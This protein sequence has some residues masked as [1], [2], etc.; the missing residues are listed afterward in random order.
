MTSNAG[1][2]IIMGDQMIRILEAGDEM[3]P[4]EYTET[5]RHTVAMTSHKMRPSVLCLLCCN[6]T[7]IDHAPFQMKHYAPRCHLIV[8]PTIEN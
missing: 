1:V 4:K 2:L 7:D 6:C 3:Y 5:R 8:L